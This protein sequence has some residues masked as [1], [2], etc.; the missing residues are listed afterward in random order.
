[1][2]DG[3]E[4]TTRRN[5]AKSPNTDGTLLG[6]RL[7]A[8]LKVLYVGKG[9]QPACKEHPFRREEGSRSLRVM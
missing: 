5:L 8:R 1:M 7:P 6:T 2:Q 9:A 4:P 3:L